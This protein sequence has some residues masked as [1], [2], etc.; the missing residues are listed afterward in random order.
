MVRQRE[1][2]IGGRGESSRV[3]GALP[4]VA[5]GAVSARA[6]VATGL[7]LRTGRWWSFLLPPREAGRMADG[8]RG[9]SV[10]EGKRS[11]GSK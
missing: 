3:T 8:A 4:P 9:G 11:K 6:I 10:G 1:V 5:S 7:R 2:P